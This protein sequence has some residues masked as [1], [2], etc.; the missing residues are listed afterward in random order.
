M[1]DDRVRQ[2]EIERGCR[3][4]QRHAVGAR[5]ADVPEPALARELHPGIAEPVERVDPDASSTCSA[6]DSGMPPPP[7]PQSS[8]R[9]RSVTPAA[10]ETR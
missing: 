6:I 1:L 10:R 7:H 4:R 5:E 9:P 2:H 8:A 3:E